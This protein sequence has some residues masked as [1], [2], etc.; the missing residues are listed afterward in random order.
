MKGEHGCNRVRVEQTVRCIR[1]I[2]KEGQSLDYYLQK[3]NL[4]NIDLIALFHIVL[5]DRSQKVEKL[6]SV[7]IN[8]Q[9][10]KHGLEEMAQQCS[11]NNYQMISDN[12]YQMISDNNYQMISDNNYQMIYELM[13]ERVRQQQKQQNRYNQDVKQKLQ[14]LIDLIGT[15]HQQQEQ[16]IQKQE[17][18]IVQKKFM[19]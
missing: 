18:K 10:L 17:K 1:Q 14:S 11:D 19:G 16:K 6:N 9:Y 2:L 7:S 8:Y 3:Y 4:D 15:E 5:Q 13:D 12:N